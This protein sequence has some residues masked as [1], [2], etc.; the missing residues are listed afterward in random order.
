MLCMTVRQQH[1]DEYS[2]LKERVASL[3]QALSQ[4]LDLIDHLSAIVEHV[5][6]G[7][8][9]ELQ[10]LQAFAA[11]LSALARA[12]TARVTHRG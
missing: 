2:Q 12:K 4:I 5:C 10:P 3:E 6:T 7:K 1:L 11:Q 9:E 8:T